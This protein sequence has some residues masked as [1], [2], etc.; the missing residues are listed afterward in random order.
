MAKKTL[1]FNLKLVILYL[2]P[3]V[4]WAGV[5]FAF[6]HRPTDS[7]SEVVW[8]DFVVKKLAHIFEFGVLAALIY[9]ALI[10]FDI[11]KRKSA[12]WAIY[13]SICYG[14]TDEVHQMFTSGRDPKVRDVLFDTIGSVFAIYYIWKLLPPRQKSNKLFSIAYKLIYGNK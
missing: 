7:V 10:E 8:Q 4:I 9:R 3:P 6:S 11:P 5:I 12:F 1:N 2:V 13:L 14:V